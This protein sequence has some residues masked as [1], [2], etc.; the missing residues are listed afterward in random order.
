MNCIQVSDLQLPRCKPSATKGYWSHELTT[1]KNDSIVAHDF[2][3]LNNCPRSGPIFEAKKNAHYRYKLR[4]RQVKNDVD[5][6]RIDELNENL[7]DGDHHKFWSGYKRLNCVT[8]KQSPRVNGL[9]NDRDIA[10]C[11]ANTYKTVYESL[12]RQQSDFLLNKFRSIYDEYYSRHSC[13]SI[14]HLLLTW[15]EMLDV[16]SHLKAGK[17]T[18]SFVKPEHVLYGS[19]K[20]VWHLHLLFNA[21]IMHSYVPSDFLKGVVSPLLKD[22]EGDVSDPSNY[23]PLTLSVIFSN[24]FEHALMLKIGHLLET[25]PL[26]FG[27]KRRHSITHAIFSLKSCIDFFINRGSRVFTAFL[28]CSKGFDRVSHH[29]IFIKLVQ[30]NVPLCILNLIIYWY[31]N[32]ISVVKWNENFSQSFS[33]SSGVR[34]GGVL[35][36]HLFIIYIDDLI[37]DLRRLSN[38]CYIADLFLACIVYADDICLLAPCRSALQA[39]LDRCESYGKEW[40]LLYNPSKSKIMV[41]GSPAASTSFSMYG[42]NLSHVNEVKYLGVTIV[43]GPTFSV[44]LVKTLIRFRSSANSILNVIHRSSEPTLM[45]LLYS[46]CVPLLSYASEVIPYTSR[47]FQPLNVALND[48]I[49]RIFGFNRWESVRF[50]RQSMG[51]PSLTDIFSARARKFK[52]RLH[53]IPNTVLQRLAMLDPS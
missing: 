30:R 39:L 42:S 20:L 16:M 43:S 52:S 13:D 38:G 44:S 5:L 18:G 15:P 32:L 51:Y 40:C 24:L 25:D 34:Q 6:D 14:K 45:K 41:F 49:R 29:G 12:D 35:S 22:S 26:Q 33:V 19:P 50:L 10:N 23:R 2:W 21:M 7:I 31:S 1:L 8:S 4:I 47:Q 3:K 17:A 53:C 37:K 11:F 9:T 36:P 28:D 48:C 46:I 27:Y